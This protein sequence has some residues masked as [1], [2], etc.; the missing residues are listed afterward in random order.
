[1]ENKHP[2]LDILVK[3]L[4]EVDEQG[5]DHP[6]LY[7]VLLAVQSLKPKYQTMVIKQALGQEYTYA[8]IMEHVHMLFIILKQKDEQGTYSALGFGLEQIS[9]C[10]WSGHQLPTT[11]QEV[12]ITPEHDSKG[13]RCARFLKF[14]ELWME[15]NEA[16]YDDFLS[17]LDVEELL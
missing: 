7:V 3:A 11:I 15:Y 10:T 8:Q 1:M 12:D 16:T 2:N 5:Y 13:L 17:E 14:I 4:I 6:Q 9:V